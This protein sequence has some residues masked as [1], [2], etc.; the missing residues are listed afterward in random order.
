MEEAGAYVPPEVAY[1]DGPNKKLTINDKTHK[2]KSIIK[3]N[4]G[5]LGAG[6]KILKDYELASDKDRQMLNDIL[7]NEYADS[8]CLLLDFVNMDKNYGVHSFDIVTI[9]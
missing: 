9:R 3:V 6:D 5:C 4:D 8:R 7:K 2:S 1:W